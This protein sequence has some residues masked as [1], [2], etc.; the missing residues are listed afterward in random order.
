[1]AKISAILWE[2]IIAIILLYILYAVLKVFNFGILGGGFF[3]LTA[4]A[5]IILW[6]LKEFKII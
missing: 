5:A 6:L 4:V 1:M 2:L 3:I